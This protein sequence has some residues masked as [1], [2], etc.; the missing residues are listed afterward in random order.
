M[1]GLV[2]PSGKERVLAASR[3]NAGIENQYR[4]KLL[5]LLSEMHASLQYWIGAALR[6]DETA[7]ERLGASDADPAAAII[8]AVRA[9]VE[10]WQKRF[11]RVAPDLAEWFATAAAER[12]DA[13][14]MHALKRAG[15]TIKFRPTAA[16]REA[17]RVAT[18]ENVSLIKSIAA[19]HLTAV[20]GIV[21][22]G[23]SVGGDMASISDALQQQFG[24]AQRRAS[25]IARDQNGKASAVIQRTRQ[26]ELGIEEA[27]WM[28]SGGGH[29]PRP[30]HL[31][32]GRERVKYKVAEG[33]FDPDEG[34]YIF[35]G[36]LI[37][38]RCV[39]R[40]VLPGIR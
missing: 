18:A 16:I 17:L 11:D 37:N 7:I 3:P 31:R 39:S 2:S 5:R 21:L 14:L 36:Q 9:L 19:E 12:S 13:A 25:L 8:K 30:S 15:L 34:K 26:L 20:E 28:H 10:R 35:P 24:V 38:C 6:R 29:V 23:V 4:W 33:W 1:A 32:A 27:I 40:P 22:R